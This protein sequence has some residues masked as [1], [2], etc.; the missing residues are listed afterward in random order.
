MTAPEY[1]FVSEWR[2][3]ATQIAEAA[4][5]IAEPL[6]LPR[7]W[8]SVYLAISEL[9]AGDEHGVGREVDL[10]TKGWLPYTLRWQFTVSE[11]DLPHRIAIEA[12]GDF[13]GRGVWTFSQQGDTAVIVYD[14]R[15]RAI[16]PLLS[17][18]SWLLRP[19]FSA[20]HRWAMARGEQ[21]LRIELERARRV[22]GSGSDAYRA[23]PGPTGA[24]VLVLPAITL[25]AA[26]IIAAALWRGR[27]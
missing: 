12:A 25:G 8:P 22:S 15:I 2:L 7:W 13:V 10:Y 4:A 1:H 17:R 9:R 3:P 23:P 27:R 5:I 26:A 18:L 16:K 24:R 21:S 19:L 11:V 6:D 20:N 14:W